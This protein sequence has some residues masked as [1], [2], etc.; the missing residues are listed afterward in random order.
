MRPI[1]NGAI[2]E[3]LSEK[4][5]FLWPQSLRDNQTREKLK[6]KPSGKREQLV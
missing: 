6:E 4:V 2:R 5:T 1:L 3:G